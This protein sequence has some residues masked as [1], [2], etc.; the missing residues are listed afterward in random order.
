MT[1]E[2]E[3]NA[4]HKYTAHSVPGLLQ[5]AAHAREVPRH[6]QPW[7]TVEEIEEKVAA[8]PSRQSLLR[9]PQPPPLWVVLDEPVI[10]RPV[11]GPT[12]MREQSASVPEAART[13]HIEVRVMPFVAGAHSATGGPLTLL[14]FDSAPDVAYPEAGHSG[15]LVE[16][17]AMVARH[18]HRYDLVHA[19]ALP[20][21]ASAALIRRA[22][23]EYETR[24]VPDLT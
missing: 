6:G 24:A 1:Y 3:A 5:T 19:R 9:K 13:P 22:V 10:R 14:S 7:C 15:E 21:E 12:V 17:R 8:R 16:D 4:V 18:S 23:K 20:P 2:A 11:G